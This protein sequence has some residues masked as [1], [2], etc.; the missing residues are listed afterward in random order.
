M[1]LR[2][3]EPGL[4]TT[5]QD[6]GRFG[7]GILGVSAAGAADTLSLR[8]GNRLVGN[9]QDAGAL[10]MT[11]VGGTFETDVPAVVA[12]AGSAFKATIEGPATS[13]GPRPDMRPLPLWTAVRVAVGELVRLG[14]TRS[15]ARCYLCARGGVEVPRVLGSVSTHLLSGIGG[16]QGRALRRGDRIEI[17][18]D[19]GEPLRR[20]SIAP[21][22][23]EEVILRGILRVTE[24]PQ[25]DWFAPE[26]LAEFHRASYEVT[27]QADRMGLRLVGPAPIPTG[28]RQMLTEGVCLG[29]VQL[30]ESGQPIVLFVEQQT[31]GGYPKIANVIAADLPALGQLRPRNRV[32]FEPVS[33]AQAHAAFREQERR[34]TNALEPA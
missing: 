5:V 2:V 3:I 12:L 32:R 11:L 34:W 22:E 27:E 4:L 15:G 30:P 23:I 18:P 14:P 9:P 26:S 16:F 20:L 21:R 8:V 25:A 33:M 19:P 6:L 10:E 29:A 24:G 31:T 13:A 17:G 1:A 7:H 28:S